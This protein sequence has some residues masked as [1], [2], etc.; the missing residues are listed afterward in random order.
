MTSFIHEAA[1]RLREAQTRGVPCAPVR[2]LLPAGDIEAAY[3]VQD[4]NVRHAEREGRRIVGRKIGLTAKAVQRQLG[5]DQPDYGILFADMAVADG[6]P[7]AAG[8][9]LQPKAEAEIALVL[10]RDLDHEDPTV[11][12]VIAAVGYALPAIEVVG[13]RVAGWDINILDT[14]ADNASSGAFVLG[15]TPRKLEGLDLRLCGMAMFSGGEPVSVGAGAACLGHPLTAAAWLAGTMARVGRPLRAGEILLTGALGPMVAARPGDRL[16]A[17]IE[18]LGS[19][20]AAFA[21]EDRKE[22]AND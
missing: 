8:R 3:A 7:I 20:T 18:G 12:E 14:I 13:S 10:D 6:E 5:V 9:V 1:L 19:V 16:E 22:A 15:T 4:E 11:A 17:R 21:G 2:D